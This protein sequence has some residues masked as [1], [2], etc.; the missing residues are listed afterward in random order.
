MIENF[1]Y[2]LQILPTRSILITTSFVLFLISF[3]C[4]IKSKK[5]EQYWK[6]GFI[7]M[8]ITTIIMSSIPFTSPKTN[9]N[10]SLFMLYDQSDIVINKHTI[11]Y[12][13][14]NISTDNDGNLY[15]NF[16]VDGNYC[17][18]YNSYKF[19]LSGQNNVPI[20][21]GETNAIGITN[22]SPTYLQ[23][24]QDKINELQ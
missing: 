17:S 22:G 16:F 12:S 9:D 14:D 13:I 18:I 6:S 11:E 21:T 2:Q 3:G 10:N 24:T 20:I 4:F 19:T 1:N 7:L 8:I 15:A 23:L 5:N